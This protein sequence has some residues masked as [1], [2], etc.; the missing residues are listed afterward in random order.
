[1]RRHVLLSVFALAVV[2]LSGA[3]NSD[4][5]PAMEGPFPQITTTTST[6]VQATAPSTT[7][8]VKLTSAAAAANHLYEA[9][10]AG[11]RT[12]ALQAANERAVTALFSRP[13]NT[14]TFRG[15]DEPSQLGADCSYRYEGGALVMH[16]TG[17]G[18]T[19]FIVETAEF[20]AD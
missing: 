17:D 20:L 11:D 15:C 13:F 19:G 5:Q 6:T 10:K 16:V 4:D 9:W 12:K 3:C 18:T 1:M 7:P 14:A 8:G 2:T